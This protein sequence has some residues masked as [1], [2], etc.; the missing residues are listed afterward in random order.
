MA[1]ARLDARSV[2]H[3]PAR[4]LLLVFLVGRARSLADRSKIARRRRG[5]SSPAGRCSTLA[6]VS[7]LHEGGERSFTLHMI[8]HE[9]IMLVATF[10]LAAS[11]PA[12]SSLGP[13]GAA[14]QAAR[15]R[16]EGAARG[17]VAAADRAGHGDRRSRRS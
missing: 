14:S 2:G 10:L 7:P 6:L 17:A 13:A 9:L 16:L 5:C 11:T 3:G 4:R 15:R 12:G 8:E 1:H